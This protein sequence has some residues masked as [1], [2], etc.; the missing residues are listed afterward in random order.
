MAEAGAQARAVHIALWQQRAR[1]VEEAKAERKQARQAWQ[2]EEAAVQRR[3]E[4][5]D[6]DMWFPGGSRESG[7]R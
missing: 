6:L 4:C 7:C 1:E 5:L 3:I 2:R